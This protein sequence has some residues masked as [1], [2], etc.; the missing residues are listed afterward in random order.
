YEAASLRQWSVF[1]L[2]NVPALAFS[3]DGQYLAVATN[4]QVV[5][6]WSLSAQREVAAFTHQERNGGGSLVFSRDGRWLVSGGGSSGRLWQV[7]GLPE[8]RILAGH[9]QSVPCVAFS[10]DG[11]F[12]VSGSKDDTAVLWDTA[13]G[14]EIHT[15]LKVGLVQEVAFSPDGKL[16]AVLA[17]S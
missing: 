6:L 7:G 2:D 4:S 13:T 11:K 1:K 10:P 15:F 9:L 17:W 16:L 5:R 8:K 3:P 12:L 14:A